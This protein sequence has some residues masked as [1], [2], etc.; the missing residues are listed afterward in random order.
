MPLLSEV[1]GTVQ[2][3]KQRW[4]LLCSLHA[5]RIRQTINKG[6]K[7]EV[8]KQTGKRWYVPLGKQRKQSSCWKSI[9]S[10]GVA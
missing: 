1:L 4:L 8:I 5:S 2:G 10:V 3:T 6:H 9:M 7:S